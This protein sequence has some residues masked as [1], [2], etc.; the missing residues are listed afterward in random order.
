MS[1]HKYTPAVKGYM[2][3]KSGKEYISIYGGLEGLLEMGCVVPGINVPEDWHSPFSL[4]GKRS[5][6][7]ELAKKA[8]EGLVMGCP[9]KNMS[10]E[11]LLV[12]ISLLMEYGFRYSG[13]KFGEEE[14]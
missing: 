2:L 8:E 14:E 13:K 12:T 10:R 5:D 6:V 11:E 9:I 3:C 4:S 1:A 7:P